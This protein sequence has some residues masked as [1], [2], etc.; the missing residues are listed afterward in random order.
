MKGKSFSISGA[1]GALPI[2]IDTAKGIVDSKE[3][4]KDIN[5]SDLAF[6]A[7]STQVTKNN[8][9]IPVPV[10]KKDGLPVAENEN[11]QI[12]DQVTEIY[13]NQEE[14]SSAAYAREFSP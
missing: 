12:D 1:S 7:S 10:S 3:Y 13:I 9:M 14:Q 6:T 5:I 4:K 11:Y 2:W 8:S